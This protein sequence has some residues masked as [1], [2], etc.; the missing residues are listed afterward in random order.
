MTTVNA[1]SALAL[2]LVLALA[3]TACATTRQ[4]AAKFD[5]MSCDQ[6]AVALQY[7]KQGR[8]ED[9]RSAALSAV[10][11]IFAKGD[12]ADSASLDSDIHYIDA[13]NHKKMMKEI[14]KRQQALHCI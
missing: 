12:A 1:R 8:S 14:R 2:A 9:R 6:L 4:Q 7:E 13:D 11:S 3:C 10:E 5:G